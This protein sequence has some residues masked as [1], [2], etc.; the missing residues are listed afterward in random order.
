MSVRTKTGVPIVTYTCIL[1]SPTGI[2][3]AALEIVRRYLEAGPSATM[4]RLS[5]LAFDEVK[6]ILVANFSCTPYEAQA[7][8]TCYL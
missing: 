2:N 7:N 4:A 8:L 3:N 1:S 6:F 5:V